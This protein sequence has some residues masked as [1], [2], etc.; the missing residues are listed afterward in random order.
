MHLDRNNIAWL[1]NAASAPF[2]WGTLIPIAIADITIEIY[3]Q[4]CFR[5]Y[6][7]PLID[8][9]KYIVI[10]RHKLSYLTLREKIACIFCGYANGWLK[11]ALMI[12]ASTE[13][14]WC[15]IR[16]QRKQGQNNMPQQE[17]FLAYGD[18]DGY[19]KRHPH[20]SERSQRL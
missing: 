9:S 19:R 15:D 13:L 6:R 20:E 16:H 8:R 1:R 7:I 18:E 5:L 10:D 11:Y 4:I 12:G 14:Y 2:I 17:S 3:H